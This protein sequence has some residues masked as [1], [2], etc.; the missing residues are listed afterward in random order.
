VDEAFLTSTT[1]E[2]LPI[3][4]IDDVRIGTGRVGPHTQRVMALFR[5]YVASVTTPVTI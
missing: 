5:A 3:V 2:V 1:K 4:Q